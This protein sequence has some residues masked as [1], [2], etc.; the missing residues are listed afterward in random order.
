MD[1]QSYNWPTPAISGTR[2]GMDALCAAIPVARGL[3]KMAD[4]AAPRVL[5]VVA[6]SRRALLRTEGGAVV[7][8][9]GVEAE[10]L[11]D[12]LLRQGAL[13]AQRHLAA[14][15]AALFSSPAD[16]RA[17]RPVQAVGGWLVSVGA[18]SEGAVRAAL[19]LQLVARVG[20]L[21]R[22]RGAELVLHAT[23]AN[24]EHAAPSLHA[25]GTQPTAPGASADLPVAVALVPCLY[26]GLLSIARELPTDVLLAHAGRAALRT[27]RLGQSLEARLAFSFAPLL[28]KDPR[29]ERLAERAA[30]RAIGALVDAGAEI[31]GYSLLLR[32]RRELRMRATA[33]RLLDLPDGAPAAQARSAFRRLARKLHPDRFHAGEPALLALSNEVMRALASAEAE[34]SAAI[35]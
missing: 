18:A 11:G 24:A 3:L 13:D 34:L 7:E 29:P 8:V 15:E 12:T 2:E 9:C 4:T 28:H 14:L 1:S 16:S 27:T 26:A 32:K 35:R 23:C 19:E 30:L 22:W 17:A 5:S 33:R 6:G 31:D 21:L 25:R 20:A 10:P